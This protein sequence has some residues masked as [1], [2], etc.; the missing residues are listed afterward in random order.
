MREENFRPVIERL[1]A[2]RRAKVEGSQAG[3][4]RG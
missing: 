2:T 3:Q 1:L 4:P